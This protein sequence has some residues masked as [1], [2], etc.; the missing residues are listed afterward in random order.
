MN[1]LGKGWGRSFHTTHAESKLRLTTVIKHIKLWLMNLGKP[2]KEG[3]NQTQLLVKFRPHGEKQ[4]ELRLLYM[5]TLLTIKGLSNSRM[6]TITL[7]IVHLLD[8]HVIG[9]NRLG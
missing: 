9:K 3:K 5:D 1:F 7:C 2:L 6:F 4:L 8:L